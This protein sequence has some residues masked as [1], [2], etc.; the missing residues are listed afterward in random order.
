MVTIPCELGEK[1]FHMQ[2]EIP[3]SI[4][5]SLSLHSLIAF[6]YTITGQDFAKSSV[7]Q[8]TLSVCVCDCSFDVCRH[9]RKDRYAQCERVNDYRGMYSYSQLF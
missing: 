6:Y 4:A 3:D 5:S 9:R 1:T 2:Q 8:L 7:Y